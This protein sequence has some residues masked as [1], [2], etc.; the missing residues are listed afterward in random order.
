[1]NAASTR[2][3]PERPFRRVAGA[4]ADCSLLVRPSAFVTRLHFRSYQTN[5]QLAP[6]K[7]APSGRTATNKLPLPLLRKGQPERGPHATCIKNPALQT[8]WTPA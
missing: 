2:G 8:P 3:L 6:P 7:G 4:R 5:R 1:M